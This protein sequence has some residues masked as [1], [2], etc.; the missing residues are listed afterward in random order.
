MNRIKTT[1]LI[2]I[3]LVLTVSCVSPK[4]EVRTGLSKED[5]ALLDT[6]QRTYFKYMWDAALPNSGLARVR[7]LESNPEKDKNTITIGSS[8]FGIAGII[9]GIERGYV[10]RK[11]GVERLE[12]IC[13]F[14]ERSDRYHG[15]WSHWIDDLTGHTIPFANPASKDNGGD[16]VESAFLAEG[17]LVAR[18]YLSAGNR[19]ERKLADR[20]DR[21]WKD[22]EWDWY[23]KDGDEVLFWHWSPDYGWEKNFP[24][25][26]YNECLIAYILGASSPTHPIPRKAYYEGWA[27][28]GDIISDT[29]LL[30]YKPI[31]V[32]N[33]GKGYVGP[34][35]WTAFSYVGF[36][37][38]GLK[39]SLN[40][41]YFDVNVSQVLVQRQFCIDNPNGVDGYSE[42][43]WGMTAG[44]ST[45]GYKAHN[46][47]TD[48]GVVSPSAV[49]A[50]LPY[51]PAEALGMIRH[52]YNDLKDDVWGP[53][54]FY[55]AYIVED[56]KAVRNYLANNEC[57]V[58]PMIE[59]F[60]TGLIWNL[61]MSCEEVRKGLDILGFTKDER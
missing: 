8:G 50:T 25:K 30:G 9:V 52:F 6:L 12:K 24:L 39:D 58:V 13:G 21:L 4:S 45:K 49:L 57:V 44:Y 14:L 61:F 26:G 42:E 33:T 38:K 56:K 16:I 22:M 18:Q 10:S 19:K 7:M 35:F 60:R 15:M 41:N 1:I 54:G 48:R 36:N 17:L 34:L 29:C 28:G 40:I 55:D 37:P 43:C 46:T 5:E 53:Y 31:V 27:R 23:L 32:H 47:K 11:E 3:A 51:A 59:N 20:F 2:L